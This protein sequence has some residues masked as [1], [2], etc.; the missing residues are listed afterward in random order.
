MSSKPVLSVKDLSVSF[1][2]DTGF[3]EIIDKVGFD[4]YPG[5][6]FGLVGESGCGKTVTTLAVQRLLPKPGTRITS[7]EILLGGKDILEMSLSDLRK[8]RGRE[9]GMIF[10]EPAAAMDPLMTVGAQLYEIFEYHKYSGN[11]HARVKELLTRVG[12]P[13]PNRILSAYPHE[14]SG[15]MLQRVMIAAALLLKPSLV[16]ADE[17]TTALDVTVQ[18]GIMELLEEMQRETGTAILFITH[19]LSLV[20]Q[21]AARVAVMYAGRIVEEARV[22]DFLKNPLHPYSKGLLAAIPDI[23]LGKSTLTPIPGQVP[24]PSEF[25]PGCRFRDRCPHAFER[26]VNRPELSAK[27]EGHRVACF[28]YEEDHGTS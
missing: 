21:Y 6:V 8:V 5:E 15:G 3:V 16:I 18:A 25:L 1:Q 26:C 14:L 11:T 9:I 23:A 12:F 22:G 10:Q 13:D 7:G 17:P 20:A 28:L 24:Q 2:T 27:E 19:N 4:I